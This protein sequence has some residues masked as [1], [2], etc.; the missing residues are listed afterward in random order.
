MPY[1]L[2]VGEEHYPHETKAQAV[3][4]RAQLGRGEI[5]FAATSIET[6]N[7]QMRESARFDTSAYTPV[8]WNQTHWGR[9]LF[10]RHYPHLSLSLK[11]KIAYTPDDLYG[12]EDRQIRCT[13]GRYLGEFAPHLAETQ[14]AAFAL[15]VRG[16]YSGAYQVADT[17]DDTARV[18]LH[19]DVDSFDSLNSCMGPGNFPDLASHPARAYGNSSLAVAYLGSI[20]EGGLVLARTVI[21]PDRREYV[22]V[23]GDPVLGSL[24]ERDGF[25]H[26][27]TLCDDNYLSVQ[28]DKRHSSPLCPYI[29]GGA[30]G[31]RTRRHGVEIIQFSEDGEYD[32]QQT[33]GYLIDEP[34]RTCDHCGQALDDDDVEYCESCLNDSNTCSFCDELFFSDGYAIENGDEISCGCIR[35]RACEVDGCDGEYWP[36][37][38]STEPL[39]AGHTDYVWCNDHS[40]WYDPDDNCAECLADREPE[41]SADTDTPIIA[42]DDTETLPLPL[43]VI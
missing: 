17:P 35:P 24:L 29:D 41:D 2:I 13:A 6:R 10:F 39:C 32:L 43:E 4:H 23:Y 3:A 21:D 33:C 18:Y 25:T 9:D 16:F 19:G 27:D 31:D 34:E 38:T 26:V 22:R 14:R 30:H 7:W 42:T 37:R 1:E 12:Y 5:M 40:V 36:L 11:G 20:A 8:P 15:A 28:L